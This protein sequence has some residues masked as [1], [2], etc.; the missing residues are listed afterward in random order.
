MTEIC[1]CKASLNKS[2]WYIRDASGNIMSTY[3]EVSEAL[4]WES[5]PIYGSSRVGSYEPGIELGQIGG[6]SGPGI[7]TSCYRGNIVYELSNH[8]GNVL[9][10]ITDRKIGIHP[11]TVG[12]NWQYFEVDY[13]SFTDYY[14][15][16]M[17]MKERSFSSGSYRF[18]FNGMEKD[19]DIKGDGNSLDFGSRVY[20]SRLGRWLSTDPLQTNYS[21]LSP[22]NFCANNP[23]MFID[24]DGER[25]VKPKN[26]KDRRLYRSQL[27]FMKK[28]ETFRAMY[29]Q[30]KRSNKVVKIQ[31]TDNEEINGKYSETEEG[32]FLTFNRNKVSSEAYSEEFFHA[33]VSLPKNLDLF[34][35]KDALGTRTDEEVESDYTAHLVSL[36][37][38]KSTFKEGFTSYP[39]NSAEQKTL[40]DKIAVSV[41]SGVIPFKSFQ[42]YV[43]DPARKIQPGQGLVYDPLFSNLNSN[44]DLSNPELN[45]QFTNYKKTS[46][47]H[48]KRPFTVA[49]DSYKGEVSNK[50][51]L[52]LKRLKGKD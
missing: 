13:Q 52:G 35:K 1:F 25:I 37:L 41:K 44:P 30:V 43:P 4:T 16:G 38:Y 6:G 21:E 22:F 10:T 42:I 50:G 11:L 9:A 36:Q 17:Q 28:S 34:R 15:F 45:Q 47:D 26:R 2:T 29:K 7:L 19:D 20:D 48:Y 8:L 51:F 46:S 27:R 40:E 32:N 23:I 31:F 24:P 12:A 33:F 39:S 18:G 5:V 49:P 14:P 3:K